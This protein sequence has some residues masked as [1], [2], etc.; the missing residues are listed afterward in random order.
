M[1]AV[2]A[3]HHE[4]KR[5]SGF[6]VFLG[7][8]LTIFG[9]LSI[10]TPYV[11]GLTITFLIGILL[12]AG[13][14][15]RIA[16][17]FRAKSWGSGLLAGLLGLLT[18]VC[19]AYILARPAAGLSALTLLLA[20]YFLAEGF[21]QIFLAFNWKPIRGWGWTLFSGMISLLLG[22]LIWM[23]WPLSGVWAIGILVGVNLFMVGFSLMMLG[24]AGRGLADSPAA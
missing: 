1:E 12:I 9:L 5:A 21:F 15:V 13:G 17:S 10:G 18:L 24:F 2:L 8:I 23:Q 6:L 14:V 22:V 16:L 11:T 4:V 19:G 3:P 20:A 7:I